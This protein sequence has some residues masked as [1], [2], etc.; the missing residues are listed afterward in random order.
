MPSY[1]KQK[2]ELVYSYY[3]ACKAFD[4]MLP[5]SRTNK[6]CYNKAKEQIAPAGL[7]HDKSNK[8]NRWG[9]RCLLP[10][11]CVGG[12]LSNYFNLNHRHGM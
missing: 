4:G 5:A 3:K 12:R 6:P 7:L 1:T 10:K 9:F 2:A 11:S 8:A